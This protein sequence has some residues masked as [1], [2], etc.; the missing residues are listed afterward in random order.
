MAIWNNEGKLPQNFGLKIYADQYVEDMRDDRKGP[1]AY[2]IAALQKNQNFAPAYTSLGIFYADIV[3]DNGRADKCFQKAFELSAGEV[4]AAERLAKSFADSK[5]WEFVGIIAQRV[6][7]A[8][9]KRSVP[10]KAVSWPHSALGVVELNNQNYPLAIQYFQA[11]LR[12]S[13]KDFHS[14]LGLGEAYASS[15]RYVAA[16][17]VFMRAEQLD[18]TNWFAKYMLANVRREMGLFEEACEGYRAVLELRPNEFGVLSALS[19]ALLSMAWKYVEGGFYHRAADSAVECLSVAELILKERADTFNL[20]KTIGDAC[21]LFSWVQSLASNIPREKVVSLLEDDFDVAEFELMADVDQIGPRALE[22]IK[23]GEANE[24]DTC[25]HLGI[26]SYKRAIFASAN[27]RHAHSVAWFN[28]G[29]AE[30]RAY[31]ASPKREMKFRM[32]AIRC[33]KRTIKLEPG[34]HEFWNALGVATGELNPKVA[35]HAIVRALY[36]N[37]KVSL[38]R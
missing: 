8:D 25:L 33:F 18:E 7:D 16:L 1:Y 38:F 10:G 15:G 26:L 20:W 14:W 19:E 13:P 22:K 21:I 35:Q 5:E 23:A 30:Y 9:K 12:I 29:T 31:L 34:N 6:A 28:L 4:E 36:I 11:A 2:F 27:D 24:L 37:D 3:G 17:K 32:A